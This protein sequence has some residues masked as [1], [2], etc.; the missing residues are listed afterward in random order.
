MKY[1]A[2][3]LLAV[4]AVAS[5]ES[6]IAD[7]DVHAEWEKFKKTYNKV[8][9]SEA[10]EMFRKKIFLD[11]KNNIRKHNSLAAIGKKSFTLGMNKYGDLLHHE[12]VTQM[13]GLKI[14]TRHSNSTIFHDLK[15]P[16]YLP[17]RI[18]WRDQGYVTDVKDQGAC[19]SCWAFSATGSLEGQNFRKTGQLTSLSEQNLIDC[20]RPFGNFGCE[21]GEMEDA[22]N[23]IE[24]NGGIDTEDSYP[25]EIN[26][27]PCRFNPDAIGAKVITHRLV[28]P[29][30]ENFLSSILASIGP[31]SI[32]V[33]A[34]H[35]SFQMYE[36]GIYNEPECSNT[37]LDH[38]VLAVGYTENY[39]IIKN[40]WGPS[41]GMNGY[42]HMPR[43]NNNYC[44]VATMPIYP[45]V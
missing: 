13:N 14:S 18:D 34:S 31:I 2:I 1:P 21:G 4:L 26:Q 37:D 24:Y 15:L 5:F 40:S 43:F 39:Y 44:G 7:E 20:S 35:Y 22:F 3:A 25:Y 28:P 27:G 9:Q 16:S 12:F 11:H 8:Y 42:M 10:E 38:A 32:A 19:G 36:G 6:S 23:Y 29:F 30:D 17:S 41:W 33:D 45:I